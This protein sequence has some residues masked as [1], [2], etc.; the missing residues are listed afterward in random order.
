M[1]LNISK[2][3]SRALRYALRTL[4]QVKSCAAILLLYLT[5]SVSARTAQPTPATSPSPQTQTAKAPADALIP[6]HPATVEQIHEYYRL[7]HAVETAHK[8][9]VQMVDGMLLSSIFTSR[10]P[11]NIC[12]NLNRF[13]NPQQA[14]NCG[15]LDERS[16]RRFICGIRTK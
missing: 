15:M 1:W 14:I 11:A 12:F 3:N 4:N 10:L 8:L 9:M 6:A 16:D 13:L 2:R 5:V 7:T